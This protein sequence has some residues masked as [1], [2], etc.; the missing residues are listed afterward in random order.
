[1]PPSEPRP[2]SRAS[3]S[4]LD[5]HADRPARLQMIVA[6]ILF[7]VLVAIP[8]YLWRRPRADSVGSSGVEAAT[9]AAAIPTVLPTSSA[10][11]PSESKLTLD[12]AK[13]VACHDPGAKKTPP[14]Q[15][16]HLVDVEKAFAKAIEDSAS[17]VPKDVG[18]G[19]IVFTADVSFKKKSL[20][21]STPKDGRSIKNVAVVAAC[22]S[23]VKAK[24]QTT[25]LDNA[26][27]QHARYRLSVTATWPGAIKP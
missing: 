6:L 11:Q 19:T 17:C 16:D 10:A 20:T 1:M 24:M 4:A 26:A 8:L 23:A 22:Q 7:L 14:E 5:A 9:S 2:S 12:A 15:C 25:S 21:V 13:V 3:L 18:G 27:H